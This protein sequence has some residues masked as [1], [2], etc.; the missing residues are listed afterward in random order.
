MARPSKS[1]SAIIIFLLII[2]LLAS[3]FLIK[4]FM[5][6]NKLMA[7]GNLTKEDV[8]TVVRDY[9]KEHPELI[10]NSLEE[11]QARK[12]RQIQEQ[13]KASIKDKSAQMVDTN[14]APYAGNKDGDVVIVEF[15]DYAC[16][17]CKKG[18]KVVDQLLKEDKNIKIVFREYPILSESSKKASKYALAV[19]KLDSNKY[20]QFHQALIAAPDLEDKT[21]NSILSSIGLDKSKVEP[22]LDDQSI[23]QF[24]SNNQ[25]LGYQI[26]LRGTP[27]FIIGEDMIPGAIDLDTF[28][29]ILEKVRSLKNKPQENNLTE[30]ANEQ[31]NKEQQ[32]EEQP[33]AQP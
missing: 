12:E 4:N 16:G 26:Q 3:I 17:Y 7:N 22:L 24:I 11:M 27:A 32:S 13:I 28:K 21:I 18:A 5:P 19:N 25:M 6:N 10:K 1:N 14:T 8:E 29:R 31:A 2:I 9:I 33:V 23:T 15:F 30:S 20:Y